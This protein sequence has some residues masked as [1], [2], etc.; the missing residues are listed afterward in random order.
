VARVFVVTI[1]VVLFAAAPAAAATVN[2][3]YDCD[4]EACEGVVTFT[5]APG[6]RNDVSVSLPA[7]NVVVVH[8]AGAP[9]SGCTTVDANTVR[10]TPVDI[11]SLCIAVRLGD[12]DDT[13]SAA[14]AEI[15]GG[16]GDDRLTVEN[17]ILN[18]GPGADVLT[19][20]G[21]Y[22]VAFVDGDGPHPA[23]DHYIG[24][25]GTQSTLDYSGRRDDLRVDLRAGTAAEDRVL[26]DIH[27]VTG[28]AGDDVLIGT[29]GNDTLVGGP[30]ADRLVGLAGDDTLFTGAQFGDP[31]KRELPA[32]DVV[33]AGTGDL[34]DC[35]PGLDT[36][37]YTQPAD[38][39]RACERIAS[40]D[41][42]PVQLRERLHRP[43]DAFLLDH[44]HRT[45]VARAGGHVVARGTRTLRLN[46]YGRA[47]LAAHGRLNVVV[48]THSGRSIVGF[49]TQL[50][51][52]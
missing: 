26:G 31:D 36:V 11:V 3:D 41:V 37:Y 51:R 39:V 52:E 14:N 44:G 24:A 47:L 5:A 34:I 43:G 1:L 38:F 42:E 18:G 40:G 21:S 46:T 32:P 30:G 12:G 28:G 19:A 20:T 49:R 45:Y 22:G 25:P 33:A 4:K 9:V 10:C 27:G 29:D 7:A 15:D 35:G 17:G 13:A 8:D 23:A 6:E 48:S 2:I 50:R 16:P